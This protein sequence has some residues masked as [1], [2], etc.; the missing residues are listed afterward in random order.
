ML[1]VMLGTDIKDRCD[2][3]CNNGKVHQVKRVSLSGERIR[4]FIE[5]TVMMIELTL[6]M[7]AIVI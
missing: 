2:N 6:I 1:H 5:S 3:Y 7:R 4:S